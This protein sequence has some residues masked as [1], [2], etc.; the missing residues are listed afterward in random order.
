MTAEARSRVLVA[1]RLELG[2]RAMDALASENASPWNTEW[3]ISGRVL[4][5]LQRQA[6]EFF[7]IIAGLSEVAA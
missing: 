5:A 6:D 4:D 1:Q 3:A 2:D 7:H